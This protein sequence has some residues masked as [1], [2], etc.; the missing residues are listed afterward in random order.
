[1]LKLLIVDDEPI[2]LEGLRD[3]IEEEKT[4]FRKI[5]TAR[6][7]IEALERI[8]LARPDLIITDIHMPEIDGL[9]LIRRAQQKDIKRFIIL[10]GHDVFDYARKAVKLQVIEYLLKPINQVELAEVLKRTACELIQEREILE[11]SGNPP[12]EMGTSQNE[13]I[14]LLKAY[15]EQS[16]MKDISLSDAAAYLNLHPV[17]LGQIFK[18]ETGNT[19]VQYINQVRIGKAKEMMASMKNLSLDTIARMVGYEN[20]RTF[21]KVFRKFNNETPG[22]FRDRKVQSDSNSLFF[23][24][25]TDHGYDVN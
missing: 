6:D 10:T 20:Q 14:K 15:I 21:Y 24:G 12:E 19:F 1:M 11:M 2:I 13:H 4:A 5:I 25:N 22:Q 16:Y 7:S 9:E 18:R 23:K 17:Y 3:M 8:E